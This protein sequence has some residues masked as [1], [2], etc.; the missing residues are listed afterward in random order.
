MIS[1]TSLNAVYPLVDQLNAGG[2]RL[3]ADGNSVLGALVVSADTSVVQYVDND[4][5]WEA[6]WLESLQADPIFGNSQAVVLDTDDGQVV[7]VPVSVHGE[8][9]HKATSIVADSVIRALG[10]ARNVVKPIITEVISNVE[11]AI[12]VAQTAVEP[13]EILPLYESDVW[14]SGL[15]LGVL[16]KF[17]HYQNPTTV[18]R[19][20][21]PQLPMPENEAADYLVTGSAELD[22]QI[23]Q[24]LQNRKLTAGMVWSSLFLSTD[25]IG[26]YRP[27]YWGDLD[28][29]LLQFLMCN[30]L[31]DKPVPNS[32]MSLTDW[33]TLL[34]RMAIAA[35]SSC[36]FM[37]R[38]QDSDKAG[39]RLLFQFAAKTGTIYLNGNVYDQ[40]IEAGGTPELVYGAVMGNDLAG[41]QYDNLLANAAKYQAAWARFHTARQFQQDSNYLARVKDA[42]Y[43]VIIKEIDAIDPSLLHPTANKSAMMDEAKK[44]ITKLSHYQTAE[45]GQICLT[46]VCHILFKHTP[47]LYILTR[48]NELCEKGYSGEEAAS[49]TVIEY[50]TDWVATSVTTS[51]S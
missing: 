19:H 37:L 42:L 36:V 3:N 14:K 39:K 10:F 41:L 11:K 47:S 15:V 34:T 17:K 24:T 7:R 46:L 22:R 32:G 8:T 38:Q 4:I 27:Q 43:G 30:L 28:M 1:Q 20:E 21:I 50:I 16:G 49:L 25:D 29:T 48:I 2:I 13:Y 51:K 31:A 6:M 26:G 44:H 9:M 12:D 35:G 5:S 45:L 40:F 33:E 23:Q 18:K